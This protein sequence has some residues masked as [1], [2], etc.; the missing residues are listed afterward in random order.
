MIKIIRNPNFKEWIDILCFD[1]VVTNV[2]TEA[3]AFH[4]AHQLKKKM[5]D[6]TKESLPIVNKLYN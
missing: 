3:K 2:K 4:V 1:L 5:K 6:K